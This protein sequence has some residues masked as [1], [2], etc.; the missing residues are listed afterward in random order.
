MLLSQNL[1][2]LFSCDVYQADPSRLTRIDVSEC[3]KSKGCYRNPKGCTESTCDMLVT[4]KDQ[5][6]Y[7]DFEITGDSDGW[8]AVGFSE[9]KK[10]VR[11][12]H[13]CGILSS[14]FNTA[15]K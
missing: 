14:E 5:G 4:W 2:C 1:P 6:E 11:G 10:M 7:V 8:V 13:C 12:I 3:G 15:S 9:D